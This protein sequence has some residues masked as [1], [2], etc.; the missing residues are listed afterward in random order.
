M[1]R[2][3]SIHGEAKA[4][5]SEKKGWGPKESDDGEFKVVASVRSWQAWLR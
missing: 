3:D 2:D 5:E 4:G 1:G